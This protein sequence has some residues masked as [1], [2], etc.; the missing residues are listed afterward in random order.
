MGFLSLK[1]SEY[2]KQFFEAH[3]RK[4]AHTHAYTYM[5]HTNWEN[6]TRSRLSFTGHFQL[7]NDSGR[8]LR[9][10]YETPN[11]FSIAFMIRFYNLYYLISTSDIFN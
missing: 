8:V 4:H 6:V 3:I 1:L 11:L 2:S 10:P 9:K 7:R 5:V